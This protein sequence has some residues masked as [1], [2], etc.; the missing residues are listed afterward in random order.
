MSASS[1]RRLLLVII[2]LILLAFFGQG[3]AERLFLNPLISGIWV[4]Q[5]V[6]AV[7]HMLIWWGI[8]LPAAL[9]L[10]LH[11]LRRKDE[12]ENEQEAENGKVTSRIESWAVWLNNLDE[13]EY[14]RASLARQLGDLAMQVL[15]QKER[16]EPDEAREKFNRGG[17]DLP[18]EIIRY[19]QWGYS[20]R[21]LARPPDIQERIANLFSFK[22]DR[23][24]IE[25]LVEFLEQE[26]EIS[27]PPTHTEES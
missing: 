18:P 24:E 7:L 21:P 25:T 4:L 14:F 12:P 2:V 17:Y 16:L 20:R 8:L 1:L 22:K 23:F 6:I 10:A 26:L 15:G 27:T 3:I 5:P 9:M 11:S 19:L 13:S